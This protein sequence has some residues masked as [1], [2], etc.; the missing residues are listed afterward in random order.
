MPR[1]ATAISVPVVDRQVSSA[2]PDFGSLD[3]DI[4]SVVVSGSK[5]MM[6]Q[7]RLAGF[8]KDNRRYDLTAQA[9]GQDLDGL[10]HLRGWLDH[11]AV[12]ISQFGYVRGNQ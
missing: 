12:Q 6:Q 8:T 9:A 1:L 4:G 2:A 3:E 5:I 7:P 11:R 10:V